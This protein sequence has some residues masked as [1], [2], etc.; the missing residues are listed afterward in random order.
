MIRAFI[1][2]RF[3]PMPELRRVLRSLAEMGRPVRD[4]DPA[5]LHIT[6]RFLG[7]IDEGMLPDLAS[8]M[9]GGTEEHERFVVRMTGIGVFPDR[10]RPRIVWVGLADDRPLAAMVSALDRQ[11]E[12]LGYE[13]ERRPWRA[14]ATLA[15]I[16][17]RPPSAF[18]SLLEEHRSRE[19]GSLKVEQINLMQS[20][21]R[22]TG[23]RYSVLSTAELA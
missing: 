17:G 10:R 13:T 14:H 20:E 3:E 7:D 6:L 1:A 8:A 12:R 21:L 23:P 18:S 19:F 2:V 9:S 22:P 16:R 11:L 4:V 5:A 15:R